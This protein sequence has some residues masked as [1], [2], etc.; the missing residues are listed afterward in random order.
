MKKTII[1][2]ITLAGVTTASPITIAPLQDSTS[3]YG[4]WGT[5]TNGT[6]DGTADTY[7]PVSGK[8]W[9]GVVDTYTLTD[10]IVLQNVGDTFEFS[11]K[12]TNTAGDSNKGDYA[13]TLSLVGASNVIAT[14][15]GG[16]S[17][18][19]QGAQVAYTAH[20]DKSGFI[21][22]D[23][24]H[25][26][27]ICE[28]TSFYNISGAVPF[29]TPATLSGSIAWNETA[30]QFQLTFSSDATG[31]GSLDPINLGTKVDVTKLVISYAG[32]TGHSD[33]GNI[34]EIKLIANLVPEPTTATLSLL[35]LAGLAARRR[36]K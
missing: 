31:A 1:A 18:Y 17:Q 20:N 27:D 29:N 15:H 24:N 3:T 23:G 32:D 33:V 35:A 16:Y 28:I 25:S 21:F 22:K 14:G 12:F 30:N 13:L 5:T 19:S 10:A 34:S 7:T 9:G 2:L 36:R 4:S 11:Y 26:T 8:K 6:I